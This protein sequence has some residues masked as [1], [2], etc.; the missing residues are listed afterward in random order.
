MFSA[1]RLIEAM[2]ELIS[3][4]GMTLAL[5]AVSAAISAC[6]GLTVMLLQFSAFRPLQWIARLY[7][8]FM[9]GTPALVQLFLIFF[10]LPML[11][12][13]LAPF[14]AASITLGLNSGAY[15]G[16]ILRSAVLALPIGQRESALAIGMSRVRIWQRVLL[17]QATTTS[18]P[19]LANELT[20]LLKT[21]PLA[22]VVAVTELT[23]A[24]QIVVARTF[25]PVEV[26]S[27]VAIG[28]IAASFL[29]IRIARNLERQA[30]AYRA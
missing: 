9:R 23:F 29:L 15:V 8:S 18:L 2:P 20:I 28:Y 27:A 22:S 11:G 19:A 10:S 12:L 13:K 25:E 30:M 16:E 26:L 3:G 5:T 7:V 4:A 1:S 21:T 6:V 14:W 17:P 24:G